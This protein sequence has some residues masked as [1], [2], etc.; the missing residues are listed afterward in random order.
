MSEDRLTA[1]SGTDL[2]LVQLQQIQ[3]EIKKHAEKKD[4]KMLKFWKKQ[5]IKFLKDYYGV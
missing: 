1:K 5:L 3:D 2:G 4:L